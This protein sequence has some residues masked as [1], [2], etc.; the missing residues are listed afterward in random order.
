MSMDR[1]P[2]VGAPRTSASPG[3]ALDRLW[4]AIETATAHADPDVRRRAEHKVLGWESVLSGMASGTLDVGSRT[5]VA[6]TP[7][8]VTLEVVH[9]GFATGRYVAEGPL[10]DDERR[11]LDQ[12][13]PASEPTTDRM[14][15][16]TWFLSDEGLAQLAQAVRE[17]NYVIAVPEHAAL[18]V[19]A[20]LVENGHDALAL[21]LVSELYPLLDR[22]RFF[23]ELRPVP[24]A[25]GA[26][27]HLRTVEDV[28]AQLADV[29]VPDD[30]AAMNEAL[31]VWRPLYDRLVALWLQTVKDGWPCATW[32]ED[33][34]SQR[35]LWLDD[36]ERAAVEHT[37]CGE[38]RTAR[39]NF[40]V[41]RTALEQCELGS[42]TL[43][44]RDVGRIRASIRR[45]IARWGKPGSAEREAVRARQRAWASR[46]TH[47]EL[48]SVVIERLSGRPPDA[49]IA[50]LEPILDPIPIG[51]DRGGSAP[52]P[53]SLT[54]KVE[55][56]L[57]APID[58]LVERGIIP[59]GEVLA[60]VLPQIS[61]HIAAVAIPDPALRELY[62]RTYAAF[63]RRR[64][65]LLLNLEHQVQIDELPWVNTLGR[66]ATPTASTRDR[67]L[68]TLKHTSL[69]ALTSFPQTIVP[70]PLVREMAA[71]AK[72]ADLDIP[73]TE[74][75]AADIFMGAFTA[76]W[77]EAAAIASTVMAG[78]LYARYY[79]L[80]DASTWAPVAD[81]A[82]GL[83]DRVRVRW[84]VRTAEDF[85]RVCGKRSREAASGDGG[86]VARNGTIIEQSQILTTHNLAPLVDRL[87]LVDRLR[88]RAQDL[89]AATFAWVVRQQTTRYD[90]WLSQLQM[91]K[92]TAYAW[93]QA[94]FF[95]SLV[96]PPGQRVAVAEL[97]GSVERQPDDWQR[98]FD[99]VVAGVQA[100]I[101]GATFDSTGKLEGGRRF[102]GWSV[103]RHW[104]LPPPS[105]PG[106]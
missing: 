71:L 65:L 11:L 13:P 39:S 92:N 103:G 74:E 40:A 85:A 16:N 98:R 87:G 68:D 12:L 47:K 101:D 45:S 104:L 83:I 2:V 62:A 5:P 37:R 97:R 89:A 25:S 29:R 57:E 8:W 6:E 48:A 3:Y 66:F 4:R 67:A 105:P 36:Y 34:R 17:G 53:Y 60:K 51:D 76:K 20:W 33:W 61:A 91:L 78:T 96:D 86:F 64:S 90:S 59:S 95:L 106:R 10:G 30:V 52:V 82:G 24:Q 44:G 41:L 93:R 21:D 49:G 43:T 1:D 58:E 56:A 22:L 32:P 100:I 77:R 27:A 15:L 28:T 72:R 73:F 84:G 26:V 50:E 14:R 54:R 99:P 55:R 69:L 70:N 35:R 63:R 79:D 88:P 31:T 18:P 7:A 102:L 19:V 42:S 46:P 9:G 94:I 38:H 81:G 80:P 23:P 75:V